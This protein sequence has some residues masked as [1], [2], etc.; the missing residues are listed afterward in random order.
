MTDPHVAELEAR[1]DRGRMHVQIRTCAA[2]S[3]VREYLFWS[4]EPEPTCECGGSTTRDHGAEL[5]S[6]ALHGA[7]SRFNGQQQV[8]FVDRTDP[9]NVA[10]RRRQ[11]AEAGLGHCYQDDGRVRFQD[12]DEAKR[13]RE[14]KERLIQ[15]GEFPA[16]ASE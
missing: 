15:R 9:R 4:N 10:K 12:R 16:P 1:L 3:S 5:A 7:A 14:Q 8:S 6:V 11:F 2:C 13:F